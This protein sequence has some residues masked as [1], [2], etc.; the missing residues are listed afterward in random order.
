MNH[1]NGFKVILSE[2]LTEVGKAYEVARPWRE[3]LFSRPW[4]PTKKTKICHPII[5]S[6]SVYQTDDGLIMHPVMFA[7][8]KSQI[9]GTEFDRT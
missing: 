9:K 5:P 4:N 3:R 8:L 2:I 1:I 7:E 6:R